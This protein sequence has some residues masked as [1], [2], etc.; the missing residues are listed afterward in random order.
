MNGI[1]KIIDRISDDAQKEIDQILAQ[2]KAQ[3]NAIREDYQAQADKTFADI[4]SL[5][6]SILLL[7]NAL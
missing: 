5:L 7:M 6:A 4:L 3:A 2:A 1:D